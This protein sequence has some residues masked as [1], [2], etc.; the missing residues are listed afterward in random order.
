MYNNL[1]YLVMKGEII[2]K[3][4]TK[5]NLY[6][7][8][9]LLDKVLVPQKRS[10]YIKN[11]TSNIGVEFNILGR[12]FTIPKKLINNKMVVIKYN[13]NEI[14][15]NPETIGVQKKTDRQIKISDITHYYLDESSNDLVLVNVKPIKHVI[16]DISVS[17]SVDSLSLETMFQF[18]LKYAYKILFNNS[19]NNENTSVLDDNDIKFVNKGIQ[20]NKTKLQNLIGNI[21]KMKDNNNIELFY[22]KNENENDNDYYNFL[23]QF[24]DYV[25]NTTIDDKYIL[26][27]SK[28]IDEFPQNILVQY[29][30]LKSIKEQ[31]KGKKIYIVSENI[32]KEFKLTEEQKSEL[33]RAIVENN[34]KTIN[35]ILDG[36]SVL[37]LSQIQKLYFQLLS[38][39][40]NQI[41]SGDLYIIVEDNKNNISEFLNKYITI[42]SNVIEINNSFDYKNPPITMIYP[43]SYKKLEGQRLGKF[44]LNDDVESKRKGMKDISIDE[45]D[46]QFS[47]SIS[48]IYKK[49]FTTISLSEFN[50]FV[51][52]LRELIKKITKDNNLEILKNIK[53]IV[54]N[55]EDEIKNDIEQLDEKQEEK[56]I[57]LVKSSIEQLNDNQQISRVDILFRKILN[58]LGTSINEKISDIYNNKIKKII[59]SLLT[60]ILLLD[61]LEDFINTINVEDNKITIETLN[62]LDLII[63]YL[64]LLE[65]N[66]SNV[67]NKTNSKDLKKLNKILNEIKIFENNKNNIEQLVKK[68]NEIKIFIDDFNKKIFSSLV[69]TLYQYLYILSIDNL[70]VQTEIILDIINKQ[71]KLNVKIT[72]KNF[73]LKFINSYFI[74][75]DFG[76]G[77]IPYLFD[78]EFVQNLS[79]D[80]VIYIDDE[81]NKKSKQQISMYTNIIGLTGFKIIYNNTNNIQI[82]TKNGNDK[83]LNFESLVNTIYD[84]LLNFITQTNQNKSYDTTN[85]IDLLINDLISLE[86]ALKSTNIFSKSSEFT[87]TIIISNDNNNSKKI[88]ISFLFRDF[89]SSLTSELQ[90]FKIIRS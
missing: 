88:E 43:I 30:L 90:D 60:L 51:K 81:N 85:E 80:K 36:I 62:K 20:I 15:L 1:P 59:E 2:T 23:E 53:N 71:L 33:L 79:D 18:Q 67:I 46:K 9:L 48:E 25:N 14:K 3:D 82:E 38:I 61:I 13:G 21:L 41:S 35:D 4:N 31:I 37:N 39:D 65:I 54:S 47:L 49:Y 40:K 12:P 52:N 75:Q 55:K 16:T 57:Q 84:K 63:D 86:T 73:I 22:L 89:G 29:K 68:I 74:T 6:I 87:I 58:N 19:N 26:D 83:V 77:E 72:Y 66:L 56:L 28:E 70:V 5:Y 17:T 76:E 24:L 32:L 78:T 7:V 44:T 69:Q 50:I 10:N 64:N 11:I 27:F 45:I 8:Y 34:Y 42:N